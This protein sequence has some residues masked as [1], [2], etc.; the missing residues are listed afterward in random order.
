MRFNY[1][2]RIKDG[3]T[4]TAEI[5]LARDTRIDMQSSY[6]RSDNKGVP[7]ANVSVNLSHLCDKRK[8]FPYHL[9]AVLE[10]G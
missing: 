5:S 10:L 7:T 6:A 3:K 8:P 1:S 2:I 9:T 4:I